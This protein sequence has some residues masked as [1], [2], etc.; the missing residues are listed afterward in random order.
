MHT[1]G[2]GNTKLYYSIYENNIDS[3]CLLS[4]PG[5][6]DLESMLILIK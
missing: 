6:Q 3:A 4:L 2:E 1:E 5:A